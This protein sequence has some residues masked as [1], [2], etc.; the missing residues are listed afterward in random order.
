M[1]EWILE[2]TSVDESAYDS[3]INADMVDLKEK[4]TKIKSK[5]S[6]EPLTPRKKEE[7][8]ILYIEDFSLKRATL[9]RK[10]IYRIKEKDG[11]YS[12]KKI[13]FRVLAE[14]LQDMQNLLYSKEREG[15]CGDLSSSI[16]LKYSDTSIVTAVCDNPDFREKSRFLHTFVI[17]KEGNRKYVLDPTLNLIIEKEVYQE[18]MNAQIISDISRERY[19]TDLCYLRDLD[20]GSSIV[21]CEYLCFPKQV[22]EGAKKLALKR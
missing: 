6:T 21:L 13:Q 18:L 10:L 3:L 7:H 16:C 22:L 20:L 5:V 14:Y 1:K 4:N 17:K 19:Y 8:P 15:K 12:Y 9:L 11:L 2:N